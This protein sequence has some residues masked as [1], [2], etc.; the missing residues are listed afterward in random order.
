[1]DFETL[2]NEY[3]KTKNFVEEQFLPPFEQYHK[4]QQLEIEITNN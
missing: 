3:V 2:K 4:E 1:M